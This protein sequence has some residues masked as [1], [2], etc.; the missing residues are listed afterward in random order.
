MNTKELVRNY[1][2]KLDKISDTFNDINDEFY[3]SRINESNFNDFN[4]YYKNFYYSI[5]FNRN[6]DHIDRITRV[7]SNHSTI[8]ITLDTFNKTLKKAILKGLGL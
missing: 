2:F 4:F 5:R 6:I 7:S 3:L 1:Y 8:N